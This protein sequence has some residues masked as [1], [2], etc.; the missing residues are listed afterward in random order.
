MYDR[1]HRTRKI[2]A[3]VLAAMLTAAMTVSGAPAA[4]AGQAALTEAGDTEENSFIQTAETEAGE[5]EE[6]GR[7][8][9]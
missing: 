8:H 7:A 2:P 9:V 1:M 5:D 3:R 6:I 4:F